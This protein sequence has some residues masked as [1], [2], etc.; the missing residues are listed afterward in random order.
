MH[1]IGFTFDEKVLKDYEIEAFFNTLPKDSIDSIE[2]APDTSLLSLS[3]YKELGKYME[4][5]NGS[6][7]FHVP[8]FVNSN[9]FDFS[10]NKSVIIEHYTKLLSIIESLRQYSV[11]IPKLVLHGATIKLAD[12]NKA[13]DDTLYMSDYLLNFIEKKNLD[14]DLSFETLPKD[15]LCIGRSR[16]EV[17][18]VIDEFKTSRLKIC[19]DLCHDFYN[20]GKYI[21]P[22]KDFIKNTNYT[23]IHGK[24]NVKHL[25]VKKYFDYNLFLKKINLDQTIN[26]ELLKDLCGKTYYED[27]KN[28]LTLFKSI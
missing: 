26:I 14:I 1:N 21:L 12:S 20:Y 11:K 6:L 8:H 15:S 25:S 22:D 5:I 17:S 7:N 18:K 2:L 16:Q 9:H 19:W 23:H 3:T 28:D 24:D 4:T 13:F 27:L 10:S